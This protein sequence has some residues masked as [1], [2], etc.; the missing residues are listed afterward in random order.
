MFNNRAF[1][2]VA[3]AAYRICRSSEAGVV[4]TRQVAASL[5]FADSVVRP[6]MIRLGDA[7]LLAATERK[8][9][10][11]APRLFTVVDASPWEHLL[12]LI[13]ACMGVSP[14]LLR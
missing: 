9:V 6:V 3:V 14:D 12:E 11:N 13:A 2:D 8:G 10:G 5:G 7:G 4:T 1:A